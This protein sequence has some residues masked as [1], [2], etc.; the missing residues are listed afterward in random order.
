MT[1][2]QGDLC[3]FDLGVVRQ[4]GYLGEDDIVINLNMSHDFFS[5]SF[6]RKAGEQNIFSDFLLHV[7]SARTPSHNH[8]MVFRSGE[9]V[10]VSRLFTALLEEYFDEALYGKAMVQGYLQLIFLRLLRL[11]QQ[12]PD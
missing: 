7:L 3:I 12:K 9:D 5:D 4:K 6:L 10:M 1:L 2:N 11:Y 8:Y